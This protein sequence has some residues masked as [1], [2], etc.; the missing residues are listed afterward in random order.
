MLVP[1][2][3]PLTLPTVS[4]PSWFHTE[5]YVVVAFE[6]GVGITY[7]PSVGS[8]VIELVFPKF[9]TREPET[10][11]EVYIIHSRLETR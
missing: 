4:A 11:A 2:S 8:R 10:D 7:A 3:S 5:P 9:T 6:T 1:L